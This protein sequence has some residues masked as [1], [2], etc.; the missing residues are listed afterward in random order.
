[1]T[2]DTIQQIK[3]IVTQQQQVNFDYFLRVIA[4][5]VPIIIVLA[6]GLGT[7]F[8]WGLRALI[9]EQKISN[10]ALGDVK[11]EIAVKNKSD[12]IKDKDCTAAH[13]TLN[14]TLKQHTTDIGDLKGDMRE[15]KAT[16]KLKP[17]T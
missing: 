6:G 15:V 14:E 4:I 10:V 13:A 11:T 9:K 3:E 2:H 7:I 12:K 17:S 5:V 1:M 16:I 8:W